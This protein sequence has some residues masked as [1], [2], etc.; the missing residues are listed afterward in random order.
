MPQVKIELEKG[1]PKEFLKTLIETTM[2][3][4]QEILK[5]PA[6]DRNIRLLEYENGLFFTK[7]PYRILIGISMFTGRTAETKKKLFQTIVNRLSEKLNIKK[8]EIF[9]LINEQP[10]ENWGIRGG[11]LANEV[12]LGFKVEI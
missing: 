4:V 10:K 5:L 7:P 8:E 9:I 3:S 2:N 1:N 12:D 11:F 6:N